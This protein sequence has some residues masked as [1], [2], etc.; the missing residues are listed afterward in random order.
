MCELFEGG[1][2]HIKNL[3][4]KNWIPSDNCLPLPHHEK[5]HQLIRFFEENKL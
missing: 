5:Y 2:A 1:M 3:K 4:A